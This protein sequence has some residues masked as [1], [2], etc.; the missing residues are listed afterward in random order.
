DGR[1]IEPVLRL[2]A[3]QVI[4]DERHAQTAEQSVMRLDVLGVEVQHDV[5]AERL[6]HRERALEHARIGRAAQMPHEVEAHAAHL[7]RVQRLEVFLRDVLYYHL[8]HA[9]CLLRPGNILYDHTI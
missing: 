8:H 6:D 1:L 2:H 3:S 5:P 7:A 4:D 9:P